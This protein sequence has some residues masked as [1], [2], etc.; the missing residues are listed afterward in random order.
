M[1]TLL[2]H[3]GIVLVV[4]SVAGP[5]RAEQPVDLPPPVSE[6]VEREDGEP[7]SPEGMDPGSSKEVPEPTLPEAMEDEP[8]LPMGMDEESSEGESSS[9]DSFS[10][11][12]SWKLSL[13]LR[14]GVRFVDPID[15]RRASLAEFRTQLQVS[16][17]WDLWSTGVNVIGDLVFDP[18][19][20][21]DKIE[22]SKDTVL[23]QL[24]EASLVTSPLEMLDVKV[25][26]QILTWGTGDLVFINDLFPKDWNAFLIGREM[27]YLKA[28]S[29]AVKFSLYHSLA[30]LDVVFTPQ[31]DPDR[32]PERR[33]LSSWD[34][35]ASEVLGTSNPIPVDIPDRYMKDSEV[36]LRLN[37]QIHGYEMAGYY[38]R[39]YWKSPAGADPRTGKAIFPE[40]SV[41]GASAR[42]SMAGGI[43]NFETGFYDSREDRKGTNGF[44]RNSELR[45]LVGFE[46]EIRKSLTMGLQYYQEYMLFHDAYEASL[47]PGRVD[48]ADRARQVLTLR[49]SQTSMRERLRLGVFTFVSPTDRDVAIMPTATY[50]LND[51]WRVHAGA[52]W[53]IGKQEHSFFG[54]LESNS[55]VNMGL[56]GVF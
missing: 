7:I 5:A 30:N 55:N 37:R 33:R 36:A 15:Q 52:N 43:L 23:L 31:F 40:L 10:L 48:L 18:V 4:A 9:S 32:Y 44:I 21:E 24:R 11:P 19:L 25:G 27:T 47:P 29:D 42:G 45:F 35:F 28:P 49:L 26:R 20:G 2:P 6:E 17:E 12:F 56:R 8:A 16:K 38:Y 41:F 51:Q 1:R 22:V 54:Q 14:G 50:A 39:G 34:P 53:F 46:K 3:I 13:D